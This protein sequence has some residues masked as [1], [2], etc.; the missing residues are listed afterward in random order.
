M[1]SLNIP[2]QKLFVWFRRPQLCATGDWQLHQDNT[3]AYTSCP[4]HKHVFGKTSSHPGDLAPLQPRMVPC[5]FWLFP[6]L[7]LPLK[8]K[9][10]QTV[11]Q[12]QEN[13]TGQLMAIG[14]ELC[15]VPR[16]LLW[17]RLRHHCPMYNISC[18]LFNKCLY[19]YSTWLDTFWVDLIE[20]ICFSLIAVIQAIF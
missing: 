16:R 7:K 20:Y 11:K 17:R 10:F 13:M 3:P 12:I 19:F 4:V 6:K 1:L 9:R 14:R 5:D 15:E 8:G 2:P 18:I